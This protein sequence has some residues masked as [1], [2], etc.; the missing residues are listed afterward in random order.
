[1]FPRWRSR[2][3]EEALLRKDYKRSFWMVSF[4]DSALASG[5]FV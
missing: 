3:I 2:G 5:D 4:P 1:M